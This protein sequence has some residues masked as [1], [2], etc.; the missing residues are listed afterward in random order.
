MKKLFPILFIA[1]T[2][3]IFFWQFFFKGLL[4]VPADTIVGL[5]HPFRDLYAKDYP[6]GIP[7]KNS[8]ITDPVRQQYPWRDLAISIEKKFELPL[9]NPYNFAGAPLLANFQSAPFYFLNILFFLMPFSSAWSLIIFLGPLMSGI[10]I[11]LYLDNLKLNRWASVLGAITSA[12]SGFFTSWLEWGT[13][14]HVGLWLPLIL[15]TIDK[16]VVNNKNIKWILIYVFSVSSSFFAGHLQIFFYLYVFSII[17][18]LARWIQF[19]KTKK[20][21]ILFAII[22]SL[23][24]ILTFVQW[25][26]T[27]QFIFLSARDVDQMSWQN[28]DWFIPWQHLIQFIAPD[29]FGN[30]AT[31]NY[32]GVWNYG[33]FVGYVGIIPLVMVI[34]ALFFRRDKKTFLFGIIFFISLIFSLPTFFAKIPYIL[35]IPFLSTAQPTRLLFVTDFFLAILASLGLDYFI[36]SKKK[37]VIYPLIFVFFLLLGIWGFVQFG[38]DV[39]KF[40]SSE[41]IIVAKRNLIFPTLIFSISFVL[42]LILIK[43]SKPNKH[44]TMIVYTLII[45][46]TVFDLFRFGLKF[47]PFTDKTYLFPE[48]K[49]ISFLQKNLGDYR[50]MTT[51]SRIFPPN[52]SAY[53]RLQSV[54]GYDPLYLLRYGELIAASERGKSN[55]EPPLGFNRIITPQNYDSKTVDLLGVKY[56]LSFSDLNSSK[57]KKVFQEGKT[58]VYENM[59][60]LQR[61]FFVSKI[62]HAKDNNEAIKIIFEDSFNPRNTAV[63]EGVDKELQNMEETTGGEVNIVH[64]SENKVIIEAESSG[65]GF[66]VLTDTFYPTWKVMVDSKQENIYR[67]DYNFRGVSVP[68]GKHRIEFYNSLF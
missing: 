2:T 4:P 31:L 65:G 26:S 56:V 32:W 48:T 55:T 41:N 43:F 22:N 5:Y 33:E 36:R 17:Y 20:T 30:P 25:F 23:C 51:D 61:A 8:L 57:L 29:F 14:T 62:V 58:I 45:V 64:Y 37:E 35:S 42:F 24:L 46:V 11:F 21:L 40:V 50:M 7:F 52:F 34:F 13:I 60:A 63:V 59:N 6:N 27:L 28:P 53:Y 54:D 44:F 16:L 39:L 10:F 1:L 19:G 15:L 66:L 9:W 12:L 47:N 18:F 67:T 49:A 3:V 38:N 68:K